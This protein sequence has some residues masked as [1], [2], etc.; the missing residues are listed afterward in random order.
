MSISDIGHGCVW[1]GE[2]KAEIFYFSASTS[3]IYNN[4]AK[5]NAVMYFI[6]DDI[7]VII[8]EVMSLR[9]D[10]TRVKKQLVAIPIALLVGLLLGFLL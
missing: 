6:D 5:N 8:K 3:I 2:K 7:S 9:K 1:I 4:F 10:I